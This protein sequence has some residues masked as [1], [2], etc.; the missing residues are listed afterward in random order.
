M[1]TRTRC[2][3]KPSWALALLTVAVAAWVSAPEASAQIGG[4][5]IVTIT[6]PT[7]GSTVGGTIP[8]SASVTMLGGLTVQGVQFKV[9]G[10]NIGAEVTSAPYSVPWDT[11]TVS[12]ASHTLTAVARDALGMFWTSDP[13]TVTVFND[14]TP[15]VIAITSPLSGASVRGTIAVNADATDNVG[16]VGV[17]FKLD[18]AN[19]GAED[20]AAPYSIVWNTTATANG[21]HTLTAVARDA[22]GNTTTSA[23]VAV[24]VSNAASAWPNEPAGLTLRTDWGM[25]QVVPT[26][27]DVPIVGSGGWNVVG[28]APVGSSAGWT[29]LVSD[30]AAPFSPSNVYDFV[31]P[32]GMVEGSAPSTVYYAGLGATE[33]YMGFWWKP[34]SPFDYGPDGNKIAFLFNGGGGAGGQQFMILLPD[35]RLH[36]LPEYPGDFRWRDPNVNATFVTLGAWHRI[37]WY[38]NRSSGA[39]KWWLDGV[40]QGSYTDVVNSFAF[41]MFQFSPTWGGNIGARKA[42]TD[43]YWFDHVHL[44]AR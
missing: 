26:S 11:R 14:K 18:G 9:D 31:Y 24:T 36:V 27:G 32:A 33:V 40:L 22:A 1:N 19:L 41:D 25:D 23:G 29:A 12:N 34:S 30:P 3:L 38:S 35:G 44:S 2:R 8:V 20:T 21:S 10:A 28:N 42:E 6:S 39:M 4:S 37:E 17:Q 7:A 5:L 43:H 13:V 15:P 16:V